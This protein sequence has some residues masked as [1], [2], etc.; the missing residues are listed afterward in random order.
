MVTCKHCGGT[1]KAPDILTLECI[2]CQRPVKVSFEPAF[3]AA[4]IMAQCEN[5]KCS[6]CKRDFP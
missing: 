1:G 2:L 6:G 3:T 4:E 5:V